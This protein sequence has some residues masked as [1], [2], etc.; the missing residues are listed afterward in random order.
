M[1]YQFYVSLSSSTEKPDGSFKKPFSSIQSAWNALVDIHKKH[2]FRKQ[3]V[4][5]VDAGTYYID[6]TI[7]LSGNV[8]VL[9]QGDPDGKTVISGGLSIK[10]WKTETINGKKVLVSALPPCVTDPIDR[11][12][13]NDSERTVAM[14][15]KRGN[16]LRVLN[17]PETGEN[18]WGESVRYKDDIYVDPE[19]FDFASLDMQNADILLTH[20]WLEEKLPV[21]SWHS[22]DKRLHL[23][24]NLLR[25][26]FNDNTE[27]RFENLKSALT[28]PGEFHHD[29]VRNILYYIPMP[30]ESANHLTAIIPNVG[31]LLFVQGKNISFQNIH[32]RHGG[33]YRPAPGV[34]LDIRDI[35]VTVP[36]TATFAAL[37]DLNLK[38]F[39][40]PQSDVHVPGQIIFYKSSNC[41]FRHCSVT[42]SVW[43]GLH[44]AAG[45]S[46]ITIDRNEFSDLGGGGIY[47]GGMNFNQLKHAPNGG[48]HHCVLTNNLIADC[49][50]VYLC[51]CGIILTHAWSNLIEHNH[52]HDLFYTG[53]SD[54]WSWGYGDTVTR[55]NRIGYN[56]IHDLGKG[57]LSD[58]GGI[59]TLGI[60][61]GTRLYGN[62]IYNVTCRYYG[63]WGIYP[64]EGS[65]HIV[66]EDN[67]CRNCSVSAFHQHFG[68]E[69]IIRRNIFIGGGEATIILSA[70]YNAITRYS[71][72]GI[73]Y[74]ANDNFC[75]N[76]IVIENSPAFRICGNPEDMWKDGALYCD[77]NCYFDISAKKS[78]LFVDRQNL[79]FQQWQD[80]GL[81]RFSHWENP[82]FRD[83]KKQDF[84]LKKTSPYYKRFHGADFSQAGILPEDKKK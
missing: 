84:R 32:F 42:Q 46:D 29:R 16:F 20:L 15:P 58:M 73:N 1:E 79:T 62:Y 38:L 34:N 14:Y 12:F 55:E 4:V 56:L 51:S 54:G 76:I 9:F 11:L 40:S 52:I 45:C 27:Y 68:R 30:G 8:P 28:E 53:I 19:D 72:P 37:T 26:P 6:K 5:N 33:S 23:A 50:K 60:Q 3:V 17:P 47:V 78:D 59:Y 66:I 36:Y 24:G 10:N 35:P 77:G 82:G 83:V 31:C 48:T 25:P 74:R 71:S 39:S 44:I 41:T 7:V 70:G 18:R 81:D 43:Y 21:K 13:V 75:D 69:N 57:V 22:E 65:S 67:L 80:E 49:G 63:G 64:D 2:P 61:P